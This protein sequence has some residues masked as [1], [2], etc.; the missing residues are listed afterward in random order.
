LTLLGYYFGEFF[1]PDDLD[2]VLITMFVV[3]IFCVAGM[4]IFMHLRADHYKK[5]RK[6]KEA[7]ASIE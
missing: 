7:D 4:G 5:V 6:A 3:F 2:A 1:T